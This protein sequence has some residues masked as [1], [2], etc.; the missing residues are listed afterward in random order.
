[1]IPAMIP[2]NKGA[3]DPRAI[4]RQRGNATSNTTTDAGTSF[5]AVLNSLFMS[6]RKLKTINR[7]VGN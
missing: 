5:F 7:D 2:E 6:W 3:F 1:M 4:P